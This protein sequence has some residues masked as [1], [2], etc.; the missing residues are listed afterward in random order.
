MKD[1]PVEKFLS[2]RITEI[3]NR[4]SS[5]MRTTSLRLGKSHNYINSIVA[6]KTIPSTK[7]LFEIIRELNVSPAE[8]F[9]PL[10]DTEKSDLILRIH[11]LSK[12]E[13]CSLLAFM[14]LY[15]PKSVLTAHDRQYQEDYI[16]MYGGQS[17]KE[18]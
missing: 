17:E 3:L 16:A 13:C 1:F 11:K 14:D 15:Y 8:F 18:E 4:T 6:C 9:M 5:T 7:M 10:Q 12:E 2:A